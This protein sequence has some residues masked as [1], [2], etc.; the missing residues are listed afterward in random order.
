MDLVKICQSELSGW[1]LDDGSLAGRPD[2]VLTD[3]QRVLEM[4]SELGL[5]VNPTKCELFF[6]NKNGDRTISATLEWFQQL[7]P[8]LEVVEESNLTLLGAA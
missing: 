4:S 7:L 8:G 3:L 1:Y 5:Q 2:E 6:A